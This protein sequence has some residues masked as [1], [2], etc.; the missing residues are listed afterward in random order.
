MMKPAQM[1][2]SK[3]KLGDLKPHSSQG[4]YFQDLS[5]AQLNDLAED[6]RANGLKVPV[7]IL[8]DNTIITGHQRC[9]A[10]KLLEWEEIDVVV[11]H[12][13]AKKG[14]AAVVQELIGDNLNR[15]QLG[16]LEAA[17]AYKALSDLRES[18]PKNERRDYHVGRF[19][20]IIGARLG[21]NGRTLERYVSLLKTPQAVQEAFQKDKLPL[22]LAEQVAR[23]APDIQ[24]QIAS[25]IEAGA[26][27]KEVVTKYLPKRKKQPVRARKALDTLVRGLA[28]S[29]EQMQGKVCNLSC[30]DSGS[31]D[32]LKKGSLLIED[33][34]RIGHEREQENEQTEMASLVS[35]S[36]ELNSLGDQQSGS[37]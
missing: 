28:A 7:Q 21:L 23:L 9:R 12:A 14:D 33:I 20:D 2:I 29:I 24:Q 3:R 25:Q 35:S 36:A 17:R 30:V 34:I 11:N 10:A 15:R 27:P 16:K 6:I 4:K 5:D 32:I 22:L 18:F 19:R 37:Q 1:E 26:D 8:P 13:L 31:M